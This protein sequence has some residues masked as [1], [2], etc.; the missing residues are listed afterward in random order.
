MASDNKNG[1]TSSWPFCY[2]PAKKWWWWIRII[3][4]WPLKPFHFLHGDKMKDHFKKGLIFFSNVAH[5][6]GPA[7]LHNLFRNALLVIKQLRTPQSLTE[8]HWPSAPES[9][10]NWTEVM[11][12]MPIT[13]SV[14][15]LSH[16]GTRQKCSVYVY[17]R[18]Y[19]KETVLNFRRYTKA[20]EI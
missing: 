18:S 9:Q 7:R 8:A 13:V 4:R 5:L 10:L 11:V 6:L 19:L 15:M 3:V 12:V 20:V 14:L 16:K 1:F 17:L 2:L